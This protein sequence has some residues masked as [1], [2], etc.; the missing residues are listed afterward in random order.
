MNNEMTDVNIKWK[1]SM[2]VSSNDV[3]NLNQPMITMMIVTTDKAGNKNNLPIEMT[4]SKFKEFF[5]TVGQINTQ[6]EN[7]KIL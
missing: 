7:A 5:R 1:V 4:T 2:A 3:K 6:M